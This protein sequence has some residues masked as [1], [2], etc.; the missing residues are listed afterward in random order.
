[1]LGSGNGDRH[2]QKGETGEQNQQV[3]GGVPETLQVPWWM[4]V[5]LSER[6][7][8]GQP[9]GKED[10]Q[11]V[12]RDAMS[13]P[14]T[15]STADKA[16]GLGSIPKGPHCSCHQCPRTLGPEA[17]PLCGYPLT[18]THA[19]SKPLLR[20]P[21]LASHSR[22]HNPAG[23]PTARD[24]AKSCGERSWGKCARA[25]DAETRGPEAHLWVWGSEHR[26]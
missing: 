1:M 26:P 7:T 14:N 13:C 6:G 18:G 5:S 17:P 10:E 24:P 12:R 8:Q 21:F 15:G 23:E 3:A 19:C 16:L 25:P 2:A 4:V 9:M 11:T 20:P 22:A